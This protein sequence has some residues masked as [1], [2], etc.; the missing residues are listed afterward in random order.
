MSNR[1]REKRPFFPLSAVAAAWLAMALLGCPL[2]KPPSRSDLVDQTLPPVPPG[3]TSSDPTGG[4]VD[5]WLASFRD[6]GL[7]AIVAEALAHNL[8][9]RSAAAMVEV[10][11]QTAIVVG[12]RLKPQVGLDIGVSGTRDDGHDSWFTSSNGLAG[13]SWEPDVWGRLR[14]Q[15]AEA[16]ADYETA[17]LDYAYARQSLA[18]MTAKAWY[19]NTEA[20]RLEA[21]AAESVRIHANLL[22]LVVARRKAGKVGDLDLAEAKG[23]LNA[24]RSELVR[25]QGVVKQASRLLETLVGRYPAAELRAHAD[26]VPVPPPVQAGLPASLLERRPDVAAAEKSV[27]A[28]FR[29]EES[30]KLALLPR[31]SLGLTGG[32]LSDGVLSLLRLNP[33]MFN[34]QLGVSIP[35]YTGGALRAEIEI[36]TLEQQAAVATYGNVA[37]VAFREVENGLTSEDLLAQRL[38]LDQAALRDRTEALRIARVQY[39]AGRISLLSVLQL[40]EA[41]LASEAEVIKLRSA[42]LANR[43]DLH[44]ALGGSFDAQPA[45]DLDQ[46][47]SGEARPR[48]SGAPRAS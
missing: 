33:W 5:G 42:Q 46:D 31:F 38:R 34:A 32:K 15:R 7:D 2:S 37:L 9:L 25:A 20:I 35:I 30:A 29:K 26:F 44:L 12:S 40:Q 14:A 45:A 4:V 11:R 18:A 10:A 21:L 41:Q 39:Q 1:V 24:A 47:A 22:D 3:W 8:D 27:L 17:A 16:E 43:I 36:A 19:D 23:N 13:A 28:A 6:P 48:A